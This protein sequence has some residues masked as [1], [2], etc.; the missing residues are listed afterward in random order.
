MADM[1]GGEK[2]QRE[3]G[4]VLDL[5]KF[6]KPSKEDTCAIPVTDEEK[7]VVTAAI[8]GIPAWGIAMTSGLLTAMLGFGIFS[9]AR[10]VSSTFISCPTNC[11][12]LRNMVRRSG[13]IKSVWALLTSVAM[14]AINSGSTCNPEY[15]GMV[16]FP[17]IDVLT[18]CEEAQ[19]LQGGSTSPSSSSSFSIGSR[20]GTPKTQKVEMSGAQLNNPR[21][22]QIWL[23]NHPDFPVRVVQPA[24]IWQVVFGYGQDIEVPEIMLKVDLSWVCYPQ[25]LL[26]S[27][28]IVVWGVG[29]IGSVLSRKTGTKLN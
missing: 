13:S 22:L 26:R 2:C 14:A 28:A 1:A 23:L 10:L 8:F 25:N 4:R 18:G 20:D 5:A 27:C 21:Y 29:F 7:P 6:K 17:W 16:G 15:A 11:G 9:V 24:E 12:L 19:I 3:W